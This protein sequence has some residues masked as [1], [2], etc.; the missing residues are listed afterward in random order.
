MP[1]S[2]PRVRVQLHREL[3]RWAP[4]AL[5]VRLGTPGT[6]ADQRAGGMCSMRYSVTR[7]LVFHAASTASSRPMG[8]SM[9]RVP[10]VYCIFV[11]VLSI[12][13]IHLP[14]GPCISI[15]NVYEVGDSSLIVTRDLYF[16]PPIV[17]SSV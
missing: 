2:W 15:L 8:G 3:C 1:C 6:A 7:L 17:P 12:I 9:G 11:L 10:R 14:S 16:A 13:G 5:I 4:I